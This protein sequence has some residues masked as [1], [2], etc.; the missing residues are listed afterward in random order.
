MPPA[1][2]IQPDKVAWR[3]GGYHDAIPLSGAFRHTDTPAPLSDRA[4]IRP[5]SPPAAA[6]TSAPAAATARSTG[7][8]RRG[9]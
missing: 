9:P 5:G 4:R 3:S 1:T 2:I 6:N 7:S 8:T